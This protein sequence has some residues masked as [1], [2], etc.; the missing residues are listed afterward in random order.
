MSTR[1]HHRD[2]T[3][4]FTCDDC[5]EEH[6]VDTDDWHDALA[7]FKGNGG[8]ARLDCGEWLHLCKDCK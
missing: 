1:R 4:T 5:G 3:I 2:K 6:E 8:V 7:D